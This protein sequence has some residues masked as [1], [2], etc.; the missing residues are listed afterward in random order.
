MIFY[1][2]NEE[3][4]D[5]FAIRYIDIYIYIYMFIYFVGNHVYLNTKKANNKKHIPYD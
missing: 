2:Y 3:V 1:V 4:S 5:M